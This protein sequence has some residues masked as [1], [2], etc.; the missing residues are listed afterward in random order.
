MLIARDRR[1]LGDHT[2]SGSLAVLGWVTTIAM[3]A[4][5]LALVATLV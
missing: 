5:A 2:A 4:A 3:A 1:V